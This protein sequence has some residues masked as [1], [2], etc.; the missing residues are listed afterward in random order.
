MLHARKLPV[1]DGS[2]APSACEDGKTFECFN[3]ECQVTSEDMKLRVGVGDLVLKLEELEILSLHL[4]GHDCCGCSGCDVCERQPTAIPAGPWRRKCR[5][6][7]GNYFVFATGGLSQPAIRQLLLAS[8]LGISTRIGTVQVSLSDARRKCTNSGAYYRLRLWT[9]LFG[10][11]SE[12]RIQLDFNGPIRCVVARA[13][14]L[15]LWSWRHSWHQS[16]SGSICST[17]KR[18][19]KKSQ[20]TRTE[21]DSPGR[22][23]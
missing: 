2:Q 7:L 10:I 8:R 15:G 1:G 21:S 23:C 14:S 4:R 18:G 13:V 6:G 5:T 19:S 11:M 22:Q 9:V 12:L 17:A 3:I 16:M 20:R